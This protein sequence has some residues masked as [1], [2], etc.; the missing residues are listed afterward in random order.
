MT[1]DLNLYTLE[2]AGKPTFVLLAG[3]LALA[4][5]MLKGPVNKDMMRFME[6]PN[7]VRLWDEESELSVREAMVV[8]R[9]TWNRL[10]PRSVPDW[11]H[12]ICLVP[13][14]DL[15]DDSAPAND[16][17]KPIEDPSTLKITV[18]HPPANEIITRKPV[19][20]ITP[21]RPRKGP[22]RTGLRR[23]GRVRP[24]GR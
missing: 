10:R 4:E 20:K 8:E 13:V 1:D 16:E 23:R 11:H 24:G 7:G 21:I 14:H 5:R 3:N 18:A 12:A 19:G 9:E 6:H 2:I 17:I 22:I 15:D